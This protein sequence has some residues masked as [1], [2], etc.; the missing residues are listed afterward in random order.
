MDFEVSCIEIGQRIKQLRKEQNL[1]Q[2]EFAEEVSLDPKYISRIE[3]AKSKLGLCAVAKISRYMD[4][5]TD[6]L[7]FGNRDG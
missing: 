4:V 6:Y 2:A 7:I 1:T 3:Q 5:S